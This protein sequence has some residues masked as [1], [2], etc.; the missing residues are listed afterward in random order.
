[1]R[2]SKS[3]ATRGGAR[4]DTGGADSTAG[5]GASSIDHAIGSP[6]GRLARACRSAG[7]GGGASAGAWSTRHPQ[8]CSSLGVESASGAPSCSQQHA[9]GAAS[10]R[11]AAAG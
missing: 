10:A 8:R 9:C 1:M 6:V 2:S 11:H 3:V 4:G 7:G 5:A